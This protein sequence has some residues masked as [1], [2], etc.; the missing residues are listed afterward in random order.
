MANPSKKGR[1][2]KVSFGDIADLLSGEIVRITG[3]GGVVMSVRIGKYQSDPEGVEEV[4]DALDASF[5]EDGEVEDDDEDVE[6]PDDY[7]VDDDEDEDEEEGEEEGE[8]EEEVD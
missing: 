6:D 4:R 3:N 1:V 7:V 2:V 5:D 8:D